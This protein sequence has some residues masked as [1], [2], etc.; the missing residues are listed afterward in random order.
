VGASFG[1]VAVALAPAQAGAGG[2]QPSIVEGAAGGTLTPAV[3]AGVGRPLALARAYLGDIALASV[4]PG[5]ISVRVQRYFRHRFGPARSIPIGAGRVSALTATMDYRSDVLVAWQ[6]NGSIYAHM[7]RSYARADPTQRLGP[8]GPKPQLQALVSDNFHGMVAWS[9]TD[10][11]PGAQAR[12]QIHLDLSAAAVRFGKPRLLASYPDPARAG[13]RPGSLAL[14]RLSGENVVLAWTA[15]ARGHYVVRAAPALVA[16]TRPTTL[17][18]DPARDAVLADL[19]P[20][21]E[22]E[23]VALWSSPA[24]ASAAGGSAAGAHGTE[25]WAARTVI[26]PGDR[27][28]SGGRARIA[29]AGPNGAASVAVDPRSDRAVVAWRTQGAGSRIA[30]AVGPGAAGYRPPAP[31]SGTHWLRITLAAL[32]AGAAL[33]LAGAMGWRQRHRATAGALRRRR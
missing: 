32:A 2:L 9:T 16:A 17:L 13:E 14:V 12:T 15:A 25:L 8:S 1:R 24:G 19:A 7:L 11:R 29:A 4:T 31:R 21:P 27:L 18:S 22:D 20:G 3:R 26:A 10:D 30:Y 6:Q 33:A 5:A 23:A 28:L